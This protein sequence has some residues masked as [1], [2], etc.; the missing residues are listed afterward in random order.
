VRLWATGQRGPAG[1]PAPEWTSPSGERFWSW[2]EVARWLNDEHGVI[3][4]VE[5]DEIR[6]ADAILVARNAAATALR[7]L[8]AAPEQFRREFAPIL[9]SAA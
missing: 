5:P 9:G 2:A 4:E 3:V 8:A 1:F 6:W 7:A